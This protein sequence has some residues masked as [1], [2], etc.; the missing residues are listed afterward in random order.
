[1][2]AR[3]L[4]SIQLI[5]IESTTHSTLLRR[6][7]IDHPLI[8]PNKPFFFAPPSAPCSFFSF[9]FPPPNENLLFEEGVGEGALPPPRNPDPLRDMD[10]IC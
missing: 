8:F 7:I 6:G 10:G 1:M 3:I 5:A 9:L 2:D 4:S